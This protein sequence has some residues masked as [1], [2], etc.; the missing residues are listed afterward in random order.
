MA[1]SWRCRNR[2]RTL[3]ASDTIEEAGGGLVGDAY[4]YC[5]KLAR[6]HYENFPVASFFLPADRR[7]AL[8]AVYAYARLADDIADEGSLP[9]DERLRRLEEW[10][11]Q[12]DQ[13][14]EGA[15]DHPVFVALADAMARYAIP[16]QPFDDLLTAF[17]WDVAR[18][19]YGSFEELLGYCRCSANPVGRIVL[20][21]FGD[22]TPQHLSYS[23]ALCTALQL[24]NFWQDLTVDLANGRCYLPLEDLQRFRY[25]AEDLQ[26]KV[27]D[28]RFRA[29]LRFEIERTRELFQAGRPLVRETVPA[30]R[31]E[32]ALTWHGGHRV[33][34]LIERAASAVLTR[35]PYLRPHDKLSVLIRSLLP[36]LR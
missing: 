21:I 18:R 14:L 29:L 3:R 7:P 36:A 20:H 33:L 25:T 26:A 9:P 10:Q 27:P 2:R 5:L 17:R 35:R 24:T 12:L 32:L 23:D 28:D 4:D 1:R 16:R 8:A 6:T 30:L 13:A 11:H 31:F 22:A 15:P 34:R 19:E